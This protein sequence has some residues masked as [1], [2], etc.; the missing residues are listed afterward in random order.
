MADPYMRQY[1][2]PIAVEKLREKMDALE[3]EA[4]QTGQRKYL[5][6]LQAASRAWDREVELAHLQEQIKRQGGK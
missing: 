3:K 1:Y 2:F 6:C 5:N 4:R